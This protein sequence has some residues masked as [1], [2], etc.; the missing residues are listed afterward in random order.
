MS[1]APKFR[2]ETL[3]VVYLV[4]AEGRVKDVLAQAADEALH[5][6]YRK[7]VAHE[8][9]PVGAARRQGEGQQ[10]AG[11]NSG[12]VAHRG[13]FP[14]DK[15][16]Q[17]LGHNAARRRDDG[18]DQGAQAEE[19][20][21]GYERGY[22]GYEHVQHGPLRRVA[23]ADVGCGGHGQVHYLFPSFSS[24]LPALKVST[25]GRRPGHT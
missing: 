17:Q 2:A 15:V 4:M 13:L 24:F 3:S 18:Q 16:H 21:P 9:D 22:E 11:D 23:A 25:R 12:K 8:N 20:D 1:T 6:D 10:H 14:H 19:H 5:D 7:G